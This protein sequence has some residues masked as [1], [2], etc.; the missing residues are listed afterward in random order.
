MNFK[1]YNLEVVEVLIKV[2]EYLAE[3]V[4]GFHTQKIR[5]QDYY[6]F[7]NCAIQAIGEGFA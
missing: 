1:S 3:K 5:V 2:M 4:K 7:E 6:Q